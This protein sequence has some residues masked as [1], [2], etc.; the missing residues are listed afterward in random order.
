MGSKNIFLP[1]VLIKMLILYLH[2][3]FLCSTTLA[4]FHQISKVRIV[5]KSELSWLSEN[6][7]NF[8]PRCLIC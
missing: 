5:L 1:Y 8:N 4:K 3:H 7:L 2:S 6:V